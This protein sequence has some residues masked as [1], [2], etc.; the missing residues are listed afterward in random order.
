MDIIFLYC[1]WK[2]LSRPFQRCFAC[3][4]IPIIK[5]VSNFHF[6]LLSFFFLSFILPFVLSFFLSFESARQDLSN[7]VLQVEKFQVLRKLGIF[8]LL[9][10]FCSP[11]AENCVARVPGRYSLSGESSQNENKK[12]QNEN[13]EKSRGFKDTALSMGENRGFRGSQNENKKK[14]NENNEK[15]VRI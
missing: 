8:T 14:Q 3:W 11:L 15:I 7:A 2:Y 4:K 5:E 10:I 1:M 9:C 13:N 12:K 6:F